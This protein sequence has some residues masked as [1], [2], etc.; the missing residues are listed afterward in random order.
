M[1]T[2]YLA[3]PC[4]GG[5]CDVSYVQ[6]L[7]GFTRLCVQKNIDAKIN[8]QAGE[9]LIARARNHL[10]AC[11]RQTKCSHLAYVDADMGWRAQDLFDMMETGLP[12]VCGVYPKKGYDWERMLKT[13]RMTHPLSTGTTDL[14]PDY[15]FKTGD[16]IRR[17]A[18]V[19][20]MKLR[21]E[22]VAAGKINRLKTPDGKVFI[23]ADQGATGFMVMTRETVE[24]MV[25]AYPDRR[26]F[27]GVEEHYN[28]FAAGPDPA[29]DPTTRLRSLIRSGDHSTETVG[30]LAVELLGDRAKAPES[31][32]YLGEDY[33][34]CRLWTMIGGKVYLYP[35]AKLTHTGMATYEG[36]VDQIFTG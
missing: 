3:T 13:A 1:I 9:S 20:N 17:R 18:T 24:K 32:K 31:T 22:D 8:L 16:E 6:G 2:P 4:Y 11:F 36:N 10:L 27:D 28:L 34:F 14:G 30:Q 29:E 25:A 35:G 23:E 15:A 21:D 19:L 33:A 12:V 5:Q 7:L 26:C